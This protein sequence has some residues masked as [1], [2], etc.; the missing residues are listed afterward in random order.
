M[1]LLQT[2]TISRPIHEYPA[3][4]ALPKDSL[5]DPAAHISS[6]SDKGRKEKEVQRKKKNEAGK[7][8]RKRKDKA[9]TRKEEAGKAGR[10]RKEK[11]KAK[12]AGRPGEV[13]VFGDDTCGDQ[14]D[15][16]PLRGLLLRK[17]MWRL[18][19]FAECASRPDEIARWVAL[20]MQR[21]ERHM[22][23]DTLAEIVIRR[24]EAVMMDQLHH[25]VYATSHLM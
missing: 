4:Q 1:R 15:T 24:L 9:A 16:K 17:S 18:G 2:C 8:G 14:E 23:T 12:K 6:Q 11:I 25:T 3:T 5:N 7:A 21:L 20:E 19:P 13:L 10:K 22:S